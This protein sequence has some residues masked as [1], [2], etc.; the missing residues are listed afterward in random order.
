MRAT[1]RHYACGVIIPLTN[2]AAH[3]TLKVS[4]SSLGIF[5]YTRNTDSKQI[6]GR[7][8]HFLNKR[9]KNCWRARQTCA[10]SKHLTGN[11]SSNLSARLLIPVFVLCRKCSSRSGETD[12]AARQ[13]L[14]NIIM[15]G[16]ADS[17]STRR[18]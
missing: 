18:K 8:G 15:P 10:Q 7:Y 17:S 2:P 12:S 3:S 6:S 14:A 13:Q 1:E 4:S 11:L 5:V 9:K 16:A